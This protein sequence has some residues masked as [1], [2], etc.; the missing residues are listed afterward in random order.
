MSQ[1]LHC[2]TSDRFQIRYTRH[3]PRHTW[4]KCRY[5]GILQLCSCSRFLQCN[6]CW[7]HCRWSR[8]SRRRIGLS[9][10]MSSRS[11][12]ICRKWWRWGSIR[13][14]MGQERSRLYRRSH[15]SIGYSRLCSLGRCWCRDRS[16]GHQNTQCWHMYHSQP[17]IYHYTPNKS[18]RHYTS[19]N[20]LNTQNTH[21]PYYSSTSQL[22][23]PHNPSTRYNFYNQSHT[24]HKFW[25]YHPKRIQVHRPYSPSLLYLY[26]HHN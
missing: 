3:N 17:Y 14:G 8:R 13:I 15:R 2:Y 4:R 22:H 18:S 9:R 19:Y 21:Y 20:S 10:M 12:R 11:R 23:N 24:L 16:I 26:M 25:Q 1:P 5:L 6:F 7:W